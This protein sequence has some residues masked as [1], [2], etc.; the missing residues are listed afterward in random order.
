MNTK[1]HFLINEFIILL[2]QL[3][4]NE[5]PRWGKLSAQGMIEHMTDSVGI[6]WE[7]IK[8]PLYTTPDHLPKAK[9][10]ILSDKPFKEN[11]PN[12]YMND[13]PPPLRNKTIN[14]AVLE[15]ENELKNFIDFHKTNP[16]KVVQNPFFGDLNYE[17]WLHLLYKHARHHLK[18][19][20]LIDY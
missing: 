9:S 20:S 11:T 3:K 17:E 6:G 16:G 8:F 15:L 18:Q 2:K 1:E 4:G 5:S 7:R 19:F 13:I 12:P 14:D 10:F